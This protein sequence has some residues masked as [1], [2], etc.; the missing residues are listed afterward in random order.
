MFQCL[1][2]LKLYTKL[3]LETVPWV[4][5][6]KFICDY[7]YITIIYKNIFSAGISHWTTVLS[8]KLKSRIL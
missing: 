2:K 3:V 7:L 4:F 6:S 5:T 8:V 1:K